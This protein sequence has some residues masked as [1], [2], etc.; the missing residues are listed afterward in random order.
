MKTEWKEY[1][2]YLNKLRDSGTTNMFG[3]VRYLVEKFNIEEN[4][5]MQIL[6][7]W[8]KHYAEIKEWLKNEN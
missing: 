2:I 8:M 4:F 1:Y 6:S 5:A 7:N 3:A